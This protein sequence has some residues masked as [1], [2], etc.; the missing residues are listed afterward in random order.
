MQDRGEQGSQID[1]GEEQGSRSNGRQGLI[2]GNKVPRMLDA[3][4]KGEAGR[5]QGSQNLEAM[6]GKVPKSNLQRGDA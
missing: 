2:E 1:Y 4:H 5:E 6:P 3:S